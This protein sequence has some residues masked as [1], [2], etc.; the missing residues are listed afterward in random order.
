MYEDFEVILYI[1]TRR[2]ER[3][4]LAALLQK[5]GIE[6]RRHMELG[7]LEE[8]AAKRWLVK[9]RYWRMAREGQSYAEIKRELSD[10][11]GISISSIEKMIYRTKK[12]QQ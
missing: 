11:F 3:E 10:Q 4:I 7:L 5:E 1:K 12:Q 6:A 8:K 9:Q 2:M